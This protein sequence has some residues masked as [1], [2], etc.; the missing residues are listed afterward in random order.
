MEIRTMFW[1]VLE[2]L[3]GAEYMDAGAKA[4]LSYKVISALILKSCIPELSDLSLK[5]IEDECIIGEPE[6]ANV[7]VHRDEDDRTEKPEKINQAGNEDNDLKEGKVTYDVRFV[8]HIPGEEEYTKVYINLEAQ[9]KFNPGYPLVK[10]GLYYDARMISAQYGVEFT[11]SDY[12]KIKKVYSIWICINPE[13]EYQNTI[14]RYQVTEKHVFGDAELPVKDYDIMETIL[15][16]LHTNGDEGKC[17]N[18]LIDMLSVLFEKNKPSK[19]KQD[20]LEK[21]YDIKMTKEYNEVMDRMC[22]ISGYYTEDLYAAKAELAAAKQELA[23]KDRLIEEKDRAV[24]EF[25]K[26]LINEGKPVDEIERYSGLDID[27]LKQIAESLG[28]TL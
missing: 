12:G 7:P 11:E 4:L 18:K 24:K 13:Q 19:E 8:I 21:D 20:K 10:R 1:H 27:T 23:A 26:M 2:K 3:E 5:T 6:I 15:V 25:A 16:C 9:N 22:N 17:G 28:K 14:N